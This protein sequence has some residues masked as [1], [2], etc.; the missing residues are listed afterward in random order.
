MKELYIVKELD[1][2][3]DEVTRY[4][5]REAYIE[6]FGTEPQKIELKREKPLKDANKKRRDVALHQI[7]EGIRL[8]KL[9]QQKINVKTVAEA[10]NVSRSYIYDHPE[11][12]E[13]IKQAE[14]D[15]DSTGKNMI[16]QI[17][18]LHHRLPLLFSA[19]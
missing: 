1:E 5:T 8:L 14:E 18:M 15:Y 7:T 13:L 2:D 12:K 17:I 19:N 11:L 10:S 9:T 6:K 16:C 4:F 3:G